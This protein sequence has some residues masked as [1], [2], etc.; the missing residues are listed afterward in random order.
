M[1]LRDNWS[2]KSLIRPLQKRFACSCYNER[3]K[4]HTISLFPNY[5]TSVGVG[6]SCF[7]NLKLCHLKL[8]SSV[9]SWF[10]YRAYDVYLYLKNWFAHVRCFLF[11]CHQIPRGPL[12]RMKKTA[13]VI[14]SSRITKWWRISLPT[15]TW[16]TVGNI[17]ST[18]KR[19]LS[20]LRGANFW[21][22]LSKL[23]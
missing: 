15:S 22:L 4:A 20:S 11:M 1:W 5:G 6:E 16:N 19:K 18:K 10:L 12:N 14:I 13:T 17:V 23:S 21:R 7:L 9:T 2:C 3:G 8:T